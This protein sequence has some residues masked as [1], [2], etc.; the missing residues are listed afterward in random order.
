MNVIIS[1][2]KQVICTCNSDIAEKGYNK[3]VYMSM[4]KTRFDIGTEIILVAVGP[5][6]RRESTR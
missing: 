6:I 2:F 4:L 3:Q 1:M 5:K